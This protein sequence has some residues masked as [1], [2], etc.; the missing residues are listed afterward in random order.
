MWPRQKLVESIWVFKVF[1][2]L[3]VNGVK[4]T[5]KES[6]A[7][8]GVPGALTIDPANPAQAVAE[9]AAAMA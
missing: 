4:H 7:I 9:M 1:P 2:P 6:Y 5:E 3:V 8:Y